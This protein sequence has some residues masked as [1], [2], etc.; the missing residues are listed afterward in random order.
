MYAE[1]PV[2][3]GLSTPLIVA[4][5]ER[6]RPANGR[7]GRKD[8][9]AAAAAPLAR[10]RAKSAFRC[11]KV[12]VWTADG[13]LVMLAIGSASW[14]ARRIVDAKSMR[15]VPSYIERGK[16]RPIATS[17]WA[18]TALWHRGTN[19]AACFPASVGLATGGVGIHLLCRS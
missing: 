5:R 17:R 15:A 4:S 19:A 3:C 16:E 2:G 10:N 12:L 11:W 9:D 7:G 13:S 14:A 18:R 6:L 1:A 8:V